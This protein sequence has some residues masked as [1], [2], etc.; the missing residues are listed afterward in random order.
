[1]SSFVVA[2]EVINRIVTFLDTK[3]IQNTLH[4]SC[5]R[6]LLAKY[7]IIPNTQE[8]IYNYNYTS[9]MSI[10]KQKLV[11]ALFDLNIQAVKERYGDE[12]PATMPGHV[13]TNKQLAIGQIPYAYTDA[14]II[15]V[16]KS[17]KCLIYQC[18]EGNVPNTPLYKFL[19]ELE[20]TIARHIVSE[21]PEYE[22]AE[23]D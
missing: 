7:L 21:L 10:D 16:Y 6:A 20:N 23:W 14:N 12:S 15:Q 18:S 13:Q 4:K 3:S 1:M 17:L 19:E 9:E 22:K 2:P 8:S 11:N 5:Y